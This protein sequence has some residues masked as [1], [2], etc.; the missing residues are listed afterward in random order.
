MR[1][2]ILLSTLLCLHIAARGQTIASLDDLDLSGLPQ[3]TQVKALRYWFDDDAGSVQTVNSGSDTYLLETASLTDGLHTLHYQVIDSEENAAYISSSVFMKMDRTSNA[4]IQSLRYWFD[5]DAGSIQTVNSGSDTY[6]LETASLTDGLHTLHYQ[7]VGSDGR[8]YYVSSGI[9]M[10]M[11]RSSEMVTA[12]KLM[13]W[14]DD[15]TTLQTAELGDGVQMLNA[16]ELT[17]GL[18]TLHYQVLCSNGQM[19]PTMSTVFMRINF[20]VD[21]APAKTF[22]YWFDDEMTAQE[23]A[24]SNGVQMLDASTL[25]EGLHTIHYQI[26]D[27]RGALGST[28]SSIFMK[29]NQTTVTTAN[30]IRYWFDNDATSVKEFDVAQ[31]TQT[32]D[33]TDLLA[34]LHTLNY[35]LIDSEGKVGVP[36]TR[37]FMRNFDNS[38]A[39]GG[40]RITRYQYWLNDNSQAKQTVML[41]NAANPYTL[42]SLLPMQ[43]EPINS[44][45]FLFEITDGQPTI[46]AKNVFHI[47]FH[48]AQDYFTDGDKTFVDYSVKQELTDME[49]LE[50]GVRATTA[51][52]TENAIK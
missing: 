18:H 19:T 51:K 22:R 40:N 1:R 23:V 45:L 15:E 44:A 7:V 38:L 31:G 52:P 27:S 2:Q 11:T 13:Y 26:R 43:K 10:K 6:L 36:V 24:A 17:E 30:S 49:W 3:P 12:S 50:S 46:Y 16:S 35:Q 14:Y 29:M 42:I 41:D 9:F 37:L 21:V 33:V 20:D 25:Q 39:E 28:V 47:R 8:S 4:S 32:L 5:D 34:G 48:D